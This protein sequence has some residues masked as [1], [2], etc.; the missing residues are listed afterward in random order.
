MTS[1]PLSRARW[2]RTATALLN[3]SGCRVRK[4]KQNL[5]SRPKFRLRDL[6]RYNLQTG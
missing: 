5:T 3:K 6:L 4:R 1:V 2:P